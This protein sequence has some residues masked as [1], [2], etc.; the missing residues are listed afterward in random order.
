MFCLLIKSPLRKKYVNL[1]TFYKYL[2][3][4]F[5]RHY[6]MK[7]TQKQNKILLIDFAIEYTLY[8]TTQTQIDKTANHLQWFLFAFEN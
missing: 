5:Y 7:Q 2:H 6:K 8:T 1:S 4:F 3:N